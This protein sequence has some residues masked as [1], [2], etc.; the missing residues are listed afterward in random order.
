MYDLIIVGAGPAGLTA[1][2]Y[3]SRYKINH[4]VLG[5]MCGSS[6]TKAHMVENWP[7]EKS[8]SGNDLL[9]KFFEHAKD[10]G[11]EN[12]PEDMVLISKENDVFKIKTSQNKDLEARA[13]MICSGTKER[14]LNIPGEEEFLGRGVSYCAICD[15]AF[16]KNKIVAVAGGGN[17]AIMATLMLSEHAQKVYI[18]HRSGDFK[19]EPIMLERARQNP[20][21]EILAGVNI[22]EIKG[23]KKVQ[24][25]I[26]NQEYNGSKELP[27]DG[28]FVEIGMIPNG[29]LLKN[30]GVE[31]DAAGHI[32]VDAGGKTNVEGLYA[33]GDVSSGSN[34]IRQVLSASAEGMIGVSSVYNFLK[35]KQSK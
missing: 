23:E 5:D 16:F 12:L 7:G 17:S 6:L 33:A 32:V 2:I 21:I 26:L 4:L 34:G 15:G 31:M 29:I 22:E 35:I 11:G 9:M 19:A 28:L 25:I 24:K 18:I 27:L 10:L 30:M 3:A 20:K 1:S 13:V 14:R 8:I